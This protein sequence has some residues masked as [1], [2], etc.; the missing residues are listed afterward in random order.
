MKIILLTT[1]PT[2]LENTKIKEEV[3]ALGHEFE[4]LDLS[5]FGF[6]ILNGNFM[7]EKLNNLNTDLI[8]VRGV[9]NNIKTIAAIL[10]NLKSRGIKIFDNNFTNSMYSIDKVTDLVKLA[11]N[12]IPVPNTAYARSFDDFVQKGANLGYPLVVKFT[13]SGKGSGVAKVESQEELIAL[14]S[15]LKSRGKDAKNYLLQEFIPY[16]YDLRVLTI[17]NQTFTMRRIPKPGEFRANFSLGGTVAKYDLDKATKNLATKAKNAVDPNMPI[18]GVDVLINS[19]GKK[20]I[21]EVNHTAGLI[22][23]EKATGVNATKL[24]IEYAIKNAN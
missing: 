1:I 3:R 14:V 11:L 21:L 6:K 24:Y 7:V 18:A 8:I 20:Y 10:K 16:V 22:G 19:E 12:G 13:R 2:L 9:M 15:D 5:N 23:I 4:L 17:G